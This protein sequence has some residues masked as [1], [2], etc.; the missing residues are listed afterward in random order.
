MIEFSVSQSGLDADPE[1]NE[2]LI[3][4]ELTKNQIVGNVEDR[5]G[6]RRTKKQKECIFAACQL[7]RETDATNLFSVEL[8]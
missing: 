1:K 4:R 5:E 3:R 8:T 7:D 2:R 6:E